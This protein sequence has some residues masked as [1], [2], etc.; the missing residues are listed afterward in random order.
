MDGGPIYGRRLC[1]SIYY[2]YLAGMKHL[3]F[4]LSAT[5]ALSLLAG[6]GG[7]EEPTPSPTPEQGTQ[8]PQNPTPENPSKPDPETPDTIL[9]ETFSSSQGDFTI[10]NEKLPSG[11]EAVW[12]FDKSYGMKATAYVNGTRYETASRLVSPELDLTGY[13][14]AFVS[15]DHA[16]NYLSNAK[17]TD[18]ISLQVTVDDGKTWKDVPIIKNPTGDNW[19]FINSGD[20]DLSAFCGNKIKIG[21]LYRSNK[22]I[23]TTWEVKNVR[24]TRLGADIGHTYSEPP[25]WL[26]LPAVSENDEFH[27]HTALFDDKVYRNYSFNYD[28]SNLVALWVAY[29]LCD[30]YTN[31]SVDR[32]E[33]WYAD[34]F[35]KEQPN[36]NRSGDFIAN[37][38]ERGHQIPSAD[39][40]RSRQLN[41]QTFY[42]TNATP[43]L[44]E[45]NEGMWAELEGKL[46]SWSKK[47]DTLYV[48]TGCVV[49]DSPKT[50]NDNDGKPVAIPDAY[51]KAVLRFDKS[52]TVNGGFSAF[53]TYVEHK[54]D[55]P[56]FGKS[57]A[58]SV[59]E[60]EKKIGFDLFVNLPARI[61]EDK[62]K[63]VEAES[64]ADVTFW[65]N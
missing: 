28:S 4:F 9:E 25:V 26:E 59:D 19:S 13:K 43:Q 39:R 6:C 60:L 34:P 27:I 29:P 55:A 64:P 23:A 30:W 14:T 46:R 57:V 49:G 1:H 7:K 40:L 20:I 15:F 8:T 63:A 35:V 54:K 41:D 31:K 42:Y 38:Y 50:V 3:S 53:A 22:D 21:F 51:F 24:V 44:A 16:L 52:S 45:F 18:H 32:S 62:A 17:V 33:S 47:S 5:V 58:I 37:G 11:I 61:G 36:L 48:V 56:K 12:V 10:D 2:S 65:W